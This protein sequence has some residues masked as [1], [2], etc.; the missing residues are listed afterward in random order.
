MLAPLLFDPDASAR[1][2]IL[3][4]AQRLFYQQGI[5]ATGIDRVI[6]EAGVT[7][8]TF[9]RHFPA[10]NQLIAT[11]LDLRHQRW[12]QGFQQALAQ[13]PLLQHALPAALKSWFDEEDYRGCAF[14]NASAELGDSLPDIGELIR[15]HKREM[16]EAIALR[17]VPEERRKTGQIMLLAEGAIVRVQL[18]EEAEA[19]TAD[20]AAALAAILQTGA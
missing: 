10:K 20:L 2:R 14:I 8:V 16:A 17:L 7:K 13:I 5:R 4:T 1:D 15:R 9:Y 18:G 6:A 12:M 19:V 3:T 11:V